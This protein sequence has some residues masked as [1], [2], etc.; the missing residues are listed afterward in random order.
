MK[1]RTTGRLLEVMSDCDPREMVEAKSDVS[2]AE[3]EPGL[4]V[5]TITRTLQKCKV[6]VHLQEF[7][8]GNNLSS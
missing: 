3:T 4:S 7:H 2:L 8:D 1:V 5:C 6:L